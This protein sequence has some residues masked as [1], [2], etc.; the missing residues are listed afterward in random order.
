MR[1]LDGENR[2]EHRYERYQDQPSAADPECHPKPF[3]DRIV[4]QD[5]F[6]GDHVDGNRQVR[7]RLWGISDSVGHDALTLGSNHV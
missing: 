5:V 7:H 4:R 2:G 1:I 6:V 3:L